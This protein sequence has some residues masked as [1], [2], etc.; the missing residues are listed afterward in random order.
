MIVT[1]TKEEIE[2]WAQAQIDRINT[3]KKRRLE[4]IEVENAAN[5]KRK[6]ATDD[7][8]KQDQSVEDEYSVAEP[9]SD[10]E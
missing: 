3:E 9:K 1:S 4:A 6:S 2:N 8:N 10:A 5:A 7:G